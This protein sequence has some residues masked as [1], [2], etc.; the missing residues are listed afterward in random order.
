MSIERRIYLE[1]LT[2]EGPL[3]EADGVRWVRAELRDGQ[4]GILPEHAPLLSELA[5]G[6]LTYADSVGAHDLPLG[7]GI[8]WVHSGGI[9]ILTG[10]DSEDDG[11]R[12]GPGMTER[13]DE[14]ED[15]ISDLLAR[16]PGTVDENGQEGST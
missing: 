10:G 15:L 6:T 4:I 2:P 9:R 7:R 8:L 11:Q 12:S 3:L 5:P 16:E 14:L 1:I 13:L